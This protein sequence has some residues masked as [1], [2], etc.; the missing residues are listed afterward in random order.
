MRG[1]PSQQ[2]AAFSPLALGLSM[3]LDYEKRELVMGRRLPPADY[4]AEL[5]MRMHRLAIV[6]GTLNGSLPASFV[7]DTGGEVISISD[8]TAGLIKPKT[9]FRRIPLKVYGASGRDRDAFL[10]PDVDLAFSGIRFDRIPVVVL[11]LRAPSALLG[12]QLGGIVGHKF[13]SKYRVTIDL[14][15]SVVGLQER[16]SRS[17]QLQLRVDDPQA[18]AASAVR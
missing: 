10:M 11:N 18:R 17:A 3:R 8:A 5:P 2:P 6:R 14:D 7:V 13:L 9:P 16:A 15:R 1:F 4:D 12:F